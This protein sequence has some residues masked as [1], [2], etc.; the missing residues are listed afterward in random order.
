MIKLRGFRLVILFLLVATIGTNAFAGFEPLFRVIKVTGECSLKRPKEGD[1]AA[2]VEAKA[3]PYGTKI[4][5]GMRSSLVVVFSEGN[6]CRVLA[7]ADLTMS[8]GT[9]NKKLKIIRLNEGTVE[10][11]LKEDFHSDGNALN[12]ETATAICGAIGCKFSVKSMTEDALRLIL[13]SCFE[14]KIRVNGDNFSAAELDEGDWLSLLTPPDLSFLRLKTERGE[15]EITIKDENHEDKNVP[16][17]KGTVLKIWQR[18]V[19][20]TGQIVIVAEVTGPDGKLI[21][22]DT[23]TLDARTKPTQP[24]QGRQEREPRVIPAEPDNRPE[25]PVVD[26]DDDRLG[27]PVVPPSF[28]PDEVD[29]DPAD[30]SDVQGPVPVPVPAPSQG[31]D[32]DPTP[33]GRR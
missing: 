32:T 29:P 2:A 4:R 12:V 18:E 19:P 25:S 30:D 33:S 9:S 11:D 24:P 7:N 16:T 23:V 21:S 15:F 28:D 17:E 14:G 3:Y 10:V 6:V 5:T 22:T 20:G 31:G 27:N 26:P 8:Q 1:F 13:I